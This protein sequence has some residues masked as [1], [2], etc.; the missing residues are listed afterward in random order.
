MTKKSIYRLISF[1]ITIIIACN[2]LCICKIN[3]DEEKVVKYA[4]SA[5]LIDGDSGRILY[6]KSA[7]NKVSVASTTKIRKKNFVK[8]L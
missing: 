4:K 2:I 6:E 7:H 3:A 8:V 1:C 5:V